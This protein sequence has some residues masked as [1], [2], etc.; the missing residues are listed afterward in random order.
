MPL[1]F[2]QAVDAPLSRAAIF[3]VATINAGAEAEATVRGLCGDLAGL[4]RAV[5]FRGA[6]RRPVLRDGDRLPR[7][8]P[9]VRRAEAEGTASVSRNPRRA[10]CARHAGRPSFPYP[11]FPYGP[12]LRTR[13]P[14]HVAARRRRVA[15]P[16]P[17]RASDIST[18][19][20]SWASS[21]AP[22]IPSRR[23]PST[24]VLDRRGGRRLRRRQLCDRAE[25][26]ARSRQMERDSRSSGRK[27]S[28]AARSS[29]TSNSATPPS[30][31]SRI[32]C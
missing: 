26:S 5:G 31:A 9:A 1:P 15:R 3:L 20:T 13:D 18:T 19:A 16:T 4:V 29:P 14:D 27:R 12:V 22:K 10:S 30:R 28:S 23:T 25:I 17:C 11:R 2:A 8:G 7:L 21:T 24:P 6:R 32:M